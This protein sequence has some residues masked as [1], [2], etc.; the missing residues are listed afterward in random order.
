M[1][2]C[3]RQWLYQC[4]WHMYSVSVAN[5]FVHPQTANDYGYLSFGELARFTYCLL[6]NVK[7]GSSLPLVEQWEQYVLANHSKFPP[8][9]NEEFL[10]GTRMLAA[11]NKI[12]S[13]YLKREFRRDALRFLEELT[14]AVLSTVA[15]RSKIGRNWVVFVLQSSLVGRTRVASST[16][17]FVRWVFGEGVDQRQWDWGLS[18]WVPVFCSTVTAVG[19]VFNEEPPWRR[20]RPVVLLFAGWFSRS[21]ASVFSMY[22]DLYG[23][24]LWSFDS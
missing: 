23:K 12:G 2:N 11:L 15:A 19:A 21:P 4:V 14:N 22:R 17:F 18:G 6:E 16:W 10:F 13:S 3:G 20:W 24:A 9:S 8:V 7:E 5:N 1:A